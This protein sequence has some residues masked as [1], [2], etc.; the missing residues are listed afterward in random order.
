M[1]CSFLPMRFLLRLATTHGA[2]R[3]QLEAAKSENVV[4]NAARNFSD[5]ARSLARPL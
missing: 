5:F 2:D 4:Q 1:E 3:T